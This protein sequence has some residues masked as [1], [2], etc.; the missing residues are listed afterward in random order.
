VAAYATPDELAQALRVPVTVKNSELLQWC[1]DAASA[2]I[3]HD[4]DRL[5]IPIPADDPIA[6]MVCIGHGVELFKLND[7]AFGAV[8]FDNTGV[9]TAPRDTFARWSA[10]LVALKVQFGVG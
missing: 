9:L 10:M 2:Q 6:H 4:A 5:D 7:A 3:D 1:V 8:G